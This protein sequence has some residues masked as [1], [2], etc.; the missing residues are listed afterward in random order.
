LLA[1]R[2]GAWR[3]AHLLGSIVGDVALALLPQLA[4]SVFCCDL[5]GV[6]FIRPDRKDLVGMGR[7]VVADELVLCVPSGNR[8]DLQLHAA[9]LAWTDGR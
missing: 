3:Q 7:A 2:F 4:Q 5:V 6:H 8:R 1:K 9:G